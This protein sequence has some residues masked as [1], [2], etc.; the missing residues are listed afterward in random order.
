[1]TNKLNEN[2]KIGFF[3]SFSEKK[4]LIFQKK[5]IEMSNRQ[6]RRVVAKCGHAINY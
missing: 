5:D 4:K 3:P 1:M 2:L 6:W